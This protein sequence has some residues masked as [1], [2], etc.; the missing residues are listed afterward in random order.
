MKIAAIISEYNPFHNGHA[1]QIA[2]TKK[3]LNAD[4]VIAIMSGNYVQRG[5]PAIFDKWTRTHL[6]LLGGI[7]VVIE[8]PT[9]YST[10]S[11]ELFARGSV[12]LL[13]QLNCIDYLSFGSEYG[14]LDAI[15]DLAHLFLNE[16]DAYKDQL[17]AKLKSGYS[18]PKARSLAASSIYPDYE[19]LL[20]GSNNILAIEYLKALEGLNSTISP[21]TIQRIGSSYLETKL[22]GNYAS[23]TAIRLALEN[24]KSNEISLTMPS[25]CGEYIAPKLNH[26]I[27]PIFAKD[28]HPYYRYILSLNHPSLEN[29]FDFP[30]ELKNRLQNSITQANDYESFID[31]VQSKN[32][33]KTTIQRALLHSFLNIETNTIE[34]KQDSQLH[35]YVKILGFKKSAG[36]VLSLLRKQSHLPLITNVHD[37]QKTLDLV[38]QK[39]LDQEIRYTCLYNN[40]VLEKSNQ[41]K[42]NDYTQPIIIL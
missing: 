2:E 16:T 34:E 4:Y 26:T 20:K 29:I 32:Y 33:T 35:S 25:A 8:L 38:G 14:N 41:V 39:M 3:R 40:L 13:T 19:H 6:A 5:E 10:A 28:C 22:H 36:P 24:N 30:L 31:K 21:F 18:Y 37:H 1:Y 7:D 17:K 11:A 23:A 9:L 42:K 15:S 12:D 27:F